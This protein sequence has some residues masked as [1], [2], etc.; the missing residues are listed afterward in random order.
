MSP[1][2]DQFSSTIPIT[3]EKVAAIE[4]FERAYVNPPALDLHTVWLSGQAL[5]RI[6]GA[7]AQHS[8]GTLRVHTQT[9][10]PQLL[11]RAQYKLSA[12][13]TL[14]VR[15]RFSVPDRIDLFFAR[16]VGGRGVSGNV[17]LANRWLDIYINVAANPFWATEAGEVI[18]FDPASERA[19]HS[20]IEIKGI[21]GSERRLPPDFSS[22]MTFY[23]SPDQ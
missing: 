4:P 5:L 19:I 16:Q 7:V 11:F 2:P 13:K 22:S 21:W 12:F 15:A 9:G 17:P 3:W 20:D 6:V 18:R 10:D 8:G 1:H 23:F 14:V